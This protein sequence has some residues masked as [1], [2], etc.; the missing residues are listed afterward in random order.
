MKE[1]EKKVISIGKTLK[2]NQNNYGYESV[3]AENVGEFYKFE[4]HV[5]KKPYHWKTLT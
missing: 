2:T 5:Q 4:Y 3:L 1:K